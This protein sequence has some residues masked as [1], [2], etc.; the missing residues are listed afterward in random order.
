MRL[1]LVWL[2]LP[3][4]L[5]GVA[6][7]RVGTRAV[8]RQAVLSVPAATALITGTAPS[9]LLVQWSP[10]AGARSYRVFR[11]TR[12]PSP[13]LVAVLPAGRNRYE[14]RHLTPGVRYAY[15]IVAYAD[16]TLPSAPIGAFA[17]QG[18]TPSSPPSRPGQ[19]RTD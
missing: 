4:W 3:V 15:R 6:V 11:S 19:Y 5:A 16:S 14:D 1:A 10:V 17:G 12:I 9:S 2:L 18:T 7:A 13:S 8:P